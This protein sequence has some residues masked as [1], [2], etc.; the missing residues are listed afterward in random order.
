M[1]IN[2][3]TSTGRR[4][5][6]GQRKRKA[7]AIRLATMMMLLASP[8]ASTMC[9]GTGT[10]RFRT[11]RRTTVAFGNAFSSSKNTRKRTRNSNKSIG[12]PIISA[13]MNSDV[14]KE[15]TSK[16]GKKMGIGGIFPYLPLQKGN[17]KEM[18]AEEPQ[19]LPN[20]FQQ[21]EEIKP[22]IIPTESFQ[23]RKQDPLSSLPFISDNSQKTKSI[24]QSQQQQDPK[25]NPQQ[26]ATIFTRFNDMSLGAAVSLGVLFL[27]ALEQGSGG[28]DEAIVDAAQNIVES[29]VPSTTYDIVA[30]A[31]GEFLAGIT[32]AAASLALNAAMMTSTS[33]SS[34]SSSST[35]WMQRG[36]SNLP[37]QQQ[38]SRM[39]NEALAES[40]YF[41]ARAAALPVL[42]STGLP[43]SF[44]ILAST[45]FATLPYELVKIGQRQKMARQEENRMLAQLLKEKMEG[46]NQEQPAYQGRQEVD[47]NFP[48]F[49][50]QFR[51]AP[52]MVSLPSKH[53]NTETNKNRMV[54]DLSALQP[55]M[56]MGQ[57]S[58]MNTIDGVEFFADTC[59]WLSY[60]V[61]MKDFSGTLSSSLGGMA[62]P[63]FESGFYGLLATLTSL[64]YADFLY[65]TVQA[66][67]V[68]KQ[69][70]VRQRKGAE[71]AQ[72]YLSKSISAFTLFGVYASVQ[73]PV[74]IAVNAFLSGGI[75][76][77][78][79]S[80]NVDMC[81]DTYYLQN[82][83]PESADM[84]AQLRAIAT[85]LYSFSQAVSNNAAA[86]MYDAGYGYDGASVEA[87]MRAILTTL[88]SLWN[89]LV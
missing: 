85:T 46:N 9:A 29:A 51:Q 55:V 8:A 67:P 84:Q 27:L 10:S 11:T 58:E 18:K 17:Q 61:L 87:Q 49:W 74:T 20:L 53:Q 79:G 56:P 52:I 89:R 82:P 62:I 24:L 43:P 42:E 66:G 54:A 26:A 68:S 45:V 5:Q 13:L 12:N 22:E 63:G 19:E 59:K 4:D 88:V 73:M 33:S 48:S 39:V 44:A 47:W 3:N 81:M 32:G 21:L 69:Q 36:S 25:Q 16:G 75:D 70:E 71:W 15:S 23:N 40:D 83:P 77:C 86:G 78:I 7:R 80:S 31:L 64:I 38:N 2:N 76:N 35:S 65:Y 14:S 6:N 41:L 28:T 34:S 50:Q 1:T 37:K 72:L 57:Q 30:I 60:S